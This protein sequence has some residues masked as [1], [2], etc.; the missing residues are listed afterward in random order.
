MIKKGDKVVC[1]EVTRHRVASWEV[2]YPK[3]G[4]IYTIRSVFEWE[5]MAGC[6]L[7][8]IKND[9]AG[10]PD[11]ERGFLLEDFRKLDSN[12]DHSEDFI[13]T[14]LT[15]DIAE[16]GLER[17]EEETNEPEIVEQ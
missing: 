11:G 8:E 2:E 10:G 5:D 16:R 4:E 1:V 7:E 17:I 14:P 9:P 3:K 15:K 13:S 12:V 6:F